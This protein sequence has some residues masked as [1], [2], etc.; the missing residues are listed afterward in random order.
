MVL[1]SE[2]SAGSCVTET[3]FLHT[4]ASLS[5]AKREKNYEALGY[6]SGFSDHIPC[7]HPS[8]AT[9]APADIGAAASRTG[10]CVPTSDPRSCFLSSDHQQS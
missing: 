9:G 1:G 4:P 6:N 2:L 8:Q 3:Q 5:A 7:P 10:L